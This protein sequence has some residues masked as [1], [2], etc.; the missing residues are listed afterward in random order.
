MSNLIP[1]HPPSAS[2]LAQTLV[3]IPALNE[4][5]CIATTISRWQALGVGWVRVVDNGSTDSTIARAREAGAEVLQETRRGY[6]AA[7]WHGLQN[8]PSTVEWILFSSADGSDRLEEPD[9]A[10]WTRATEAGADLVMG[11]RLGHETARRH[12]KLIQCFGNWLCCL[13]IWLHWGRRFNDM[14]S[15]R[16]VRRAALEKMRLQDRSFGWNIEMQVRAVELQLSIIELPVRYYPRMAGQ[17]KISGTVR[18]TCR[19]AW[20]M[21]RTILKLRL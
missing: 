9:L 5:L 21:L 18:G 14:S 2:F 1:R 13:L 4:E 8:L 19:A 15:L 6:G 10:P 17:S 3:L 16:L 7:C 20:G 11:N 12:L